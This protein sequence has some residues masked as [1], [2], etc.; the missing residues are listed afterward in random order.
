MSPKVLKL[1]FE[2]SEC[3][4]LMVGGALA[5]IGTADGEAVVGGLAG[6]YTRSLFSST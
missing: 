2:V 4:P 6:A 3:K 1:S 5:A